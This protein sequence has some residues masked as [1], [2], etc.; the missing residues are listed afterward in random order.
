[1]EVN[2]RNPH[3]WLPLLYRLNGGGGKEALCDIGGKV[4][5]GN[6]KAEIPV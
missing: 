6:V 3:P 1:M 5:I 2:P 4:Q